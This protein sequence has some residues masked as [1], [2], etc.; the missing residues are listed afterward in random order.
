MVERRSLELV[1]QVGV[2][3][4]LQHAE[5]GVRRP[6]RPHQR[7]RDRVLSP[8]DTR[9]LPASTISRATASIR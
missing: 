8:S 5:S 6:D 3:V 7:S 9:N 2:C 4:E 1:A